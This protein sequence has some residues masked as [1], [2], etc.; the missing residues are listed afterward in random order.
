MSIWRI[1]EWSPSLGRGAIESPQLGRLAFDGHYGNVHDFRVGEAVHVE[2]ERAGASWRVTRIWPEDG[3][4]RATVPVA[5]PA[6]PL[7]PALHE[8]LA[9]SL[10]SLPLCEDYRVRSQ[11][12][13]ALIIEGSN[14]GFLH[15][16]MH[17]IVVRAPTYVELPTRFSPTALRPADQHERDYLTTR[18]DDLTA[19][20]VAITIVAQPSRFYFVV[21]ESVT[22]IQR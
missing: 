18:I 8:P 2:L 4:F 9:A 12:H 3:R 1:V 6:P 13:E 17:E 14:Y 15:G 10:S 22:V 7:E 16:A 21:G 5:Q 11:G 19:R 20:D